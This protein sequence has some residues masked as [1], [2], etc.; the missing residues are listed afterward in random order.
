MFRF[1]GKDQVQALDFPIK[2]EIFIGVTCAVTKQGL[3]HICYSLYRAN[4]DVS[5]SGI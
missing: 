4:V 2:S 5:V 1:D 3:S